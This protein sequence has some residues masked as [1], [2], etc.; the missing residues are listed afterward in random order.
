MILTL[1]FALVVFASLW[2]YLSYMGVLNFK[3]SEH[4]MEEHLPGRPA[5]R[6][7][8][9]KNED[10]MKV[11]MGIMTCYIILCGA[12]YAT[13][14][15]R[16]LVT[17]FI[18]LIIVVVL[19]AFA[20]YMVTPFNRLSHAYATMG[21]ISIIHLCCSLSA[22]ITWLALLHGNYLDLID[23]AGLVALIIGAMLIVSKR[24]GKK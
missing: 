8:G 13:P 1:F 3:K 19:S 18:M 16:S 22:F 11:I 20:L 9:R 10:V 5:R 24:Q 6:T 2:P 7:I 14:D 21:Q 15:I 23:I 12:L 17:D 4:M